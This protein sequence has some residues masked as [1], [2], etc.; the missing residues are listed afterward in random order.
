MF[1]QRAAAVLLLLGAL[2]L[3]LGP[4]SVAAVALVDG[5]WAL[6][7]SASAPLSLLPPGFF[8]FGVWSSVRRQIARSDASRW[9]PVP[10]C[11]ERRP[12]DAKLQP[13]SQVTT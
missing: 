4:V 6:A 5:D 8:G 9:A 1:I 10:R 7:L 11:A 13:P 2:I 3:L 12:E